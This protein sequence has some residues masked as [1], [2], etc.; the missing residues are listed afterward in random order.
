MARN[1]ALYPWLQVCHNLLFWM[2]VF[3]LF[4]SSVL[5]LQQVLLLEALWWGGWAVATS[6]GAWINVG[7]LTWSGRSKALLAIEAVFLRS[8]PP[9]LLAAVATGAGGLI[10]VHASAVLGRGHL[11][12]LA[13]LGA[14]ILCA[15]LVFGAG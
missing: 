1:L 7:I 2:P 13:G 10:G 14:G 15:G 5:P 11:A 8:L 6:I 12:H 4:F 9:V 3:F